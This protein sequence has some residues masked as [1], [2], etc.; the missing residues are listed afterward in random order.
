[1]LVVE[2]RLDEAAGDHGD[3][4]IRISLQI[5]DI[6]GR[7]YDPMLDIAAVEFFTALEIRVEIIETETGAVHR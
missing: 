6:I 5:D 1:M 2:D 7:L 4:R 3:A